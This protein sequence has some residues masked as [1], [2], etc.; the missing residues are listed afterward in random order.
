M[1]HA[2]HLQSN[3]MNSCGSSNTSTRLRGSKCIETQDESVNQG[4]EAEKEDD[5]V[6]SNYGVNDFNVPRSTLVICPRNSNY[7][8]DH[9]FGRFKPR[10]ASCCHCDLIVAVL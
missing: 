4:A 3:V 9:S 8:S 5:S 7:S 6:I 2:D 1:G 10:F